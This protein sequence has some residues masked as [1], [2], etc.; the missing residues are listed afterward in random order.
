MLSQVVSN[1]NLPPPSNQ[2]FLNQAYLD[3]LHRAPDA[4]GLA[5][6]TAALN[7]GATRMGVAMGIDTS[8]E[9]Y[10]LVV[11][12]LYQR[13]LGRSADPSGLSTGVQMLN[14]GDTIEEV[15]AFIAGS[16]EFFQNQRGGT[17]AGFLNALYEDA[18]GRALDSSGQTTYTGAL[19]AG[20]NR[21][22][23]ALAVLTSLEFR[24]NLVQGYYQSFL[25]RAADPGG[26]GAFVGD[27]E[28]GDRDELVIAA[29]VGSDEYFQML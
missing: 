7:Q 14:A 2:A 12:G 9:Y 18:L 8:S 4:S 24:E 26:L 16:P 23:V 10:T 13:Y 17:N 15:A 3:L 5:A 1:P 19:A 28:R 22:Q 27:L 25:H 6:F 21:S 29:I 11:Q 20:V